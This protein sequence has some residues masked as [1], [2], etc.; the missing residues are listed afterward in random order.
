MLKLR[1]LLVIWCGCAWAFAAWPLIGGGWKDWP[2][3]AQTYAQWALYRASLNFLPYAL[4][5]L[6]ASSVLLLTGVALLFFRISLGKIIF[7]LG[8]LL[9]AYSKFN[10]IPTIASSAELGLYAGFYVLSGLVLGFRVPV[11]AGDNVPAE[12]ETSN[13]PL[14][15]ETSKG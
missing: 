8:L 10:F 6:L 11:G 15:A 13:D 1:I 7:C 14:P 12:L 3:E 5:A 2:I 4:Q 9:H